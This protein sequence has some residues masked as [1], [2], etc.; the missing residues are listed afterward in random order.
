M[1]TFSVLRIDTV[2]EVVFQ[3]QMKLIFADSQ[4]FLSRTD[5]SQ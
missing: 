3:K 4:L 1:L 5:D 2:G